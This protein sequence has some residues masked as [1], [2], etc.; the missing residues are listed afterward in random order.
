M[1]SGGGSNFKRALA[2]QPSF[3]WP[4]IYVKT[5]LY[6]YSITSGYYGSQT[7]RNVDRFLAI[8]YTVLKVQNEISKLTYIA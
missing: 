5:L 6:G 4:A 7:S 8:R 2:S 3:F 1:C